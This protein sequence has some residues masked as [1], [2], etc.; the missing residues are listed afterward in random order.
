MDTP[1]P[2]GLDQLHL[3]DALARSWDLDAGPLHY[4][5]KGSGSYHWLTETPAHRYFLTVDD[6]DIKPWLGGNPD[7]TF[8]GLEAAY[9]TAL[10]LH[11]HANLSFVVAPIP[12]NGGGT[13]VRLSERY[14]VTVFPF[15]DGESGAWGIRSAGRTAS[16]DCDSSPSCTG[17]Q[18]QWLLERPGMACSSRAERY[19]SPLSMTSTA[20]G[21]V[22]PSPNRRDAN[23]PITPRQSR[24]G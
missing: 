11:R 5:P 8:E 12:R 24:S 21:P 15:L 19:W 3:A 23:W 17:R 18:R 14:A 16:N 13:T 20:L 4:I 1:P 7:S 22:V 10:A 9:D 2:P 6:L